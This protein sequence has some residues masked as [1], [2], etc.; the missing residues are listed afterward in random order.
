MIAAKLICK[1]VF[2]TLQKH[3]N[4]RWLMSI[5]FPILILNAWLVI[6]TLQYFQPLVAI[7]ILAALLAFI[8]NYPV[9]FLQQHGNRHS[10]AVVVVFL[11]TLLILMGLGITL[12]PRLIEEL[13]QIVVTIPDWIEVSNQRLENLQ[14]WA[15]QRQL[16]VSLSLLDAPITKL[17]SD[18][19][20][21]IAN[22]LLSLTMSTVGSATDIVFTI[23]LTFY[24]LLDGES[25]WQG[26]FQ[27]M[28]NH[29]TTLCEQ[30]LTQ[31][32]QNYIIGQI[33]LASLMGSSMMVLFLLLKIPFALLF[34]LGIGVLTLIPLGGFLGMC[35]TGLV[36]T[37]Q[38]PVVGLKT[39]ALALL[40]DQIIDQAIA[41]RLLG[42]FTGLKPA[43][44][45]IALFIGT[46]LFGLLGL[47]VSVPLAGF[48]K[49]TLHELRNASVNPVIGLEVP[50]TSDHS[51]L[52]KQPVQ[53]L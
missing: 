43:W 52:E 22:P 35:L 51:P 46:K 2:N 53:Q 12:V 23:V 38:D 49:D 29:V 33:T 41:P 4:P 50:A 31:N 18:G 7:V 8:L 21:S 26:I 10:V 27:W 28:P 44:I 30:S 36:I 37:I 13:S 34:G 32:F 19:L 14:A 6:K 9:Q 48:V 15:E 39:F 47:I 5:V 45:L 11:L 42:R 40:I 3:I 1:P 17:S 16:P 20:Q 25:I 24:F